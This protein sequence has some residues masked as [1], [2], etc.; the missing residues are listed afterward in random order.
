MLL[1][2][3]MDNERDAMRRQHPPV[4]VRCEQC[5]SRRRGKVLERRERHLVGPVHLR[6]VVRV[7]RVGRVKPEMRLE[8]HPAATAPRLG[9]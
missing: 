5:P 6:Q 3:R 8:T 2:W 1:A 9:A 7:G 4:P